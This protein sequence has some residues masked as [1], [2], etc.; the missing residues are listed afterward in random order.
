M[1][2]YR[3]YGQSDDAPSNRLVDAK[4]ASRKDEPF[5]LGIHS[6]MGNCDPVL[7]EARGQAVQSHHRAP[8]QGAVVVGNE[9]KFGQGLGGAGQN[10]ST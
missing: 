7:E 3:E 8:V 6:D 10:T 1:G 2:W 9:A 4:S 5:D